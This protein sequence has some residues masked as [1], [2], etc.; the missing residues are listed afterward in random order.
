MTEQDWHV[1]LFNIARAVAPLDD[2]ILAEF[3][4]SL[5]RINARADQTDG[6]IWRFQTESGNATEERAYPDDRVI[7]NL[8]VWRDIESL[9][10]F[11]YRGDHA[12]IMRR[13][14]EWFERMTETY[15]VLWWVRAG[16]IPSVSDAKS[17]LAYVRQFGLSSQGF[18][19]QERYPP[20][21][22]NESR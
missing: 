4:G 19:F 13:R 3:M 18:N 17:R 8:S 16:T 15:L 6:L 2:P 1:A 22:P 20:P 14:R 11:T 12:E 5:D 21:L 9:R 7:I 10:E